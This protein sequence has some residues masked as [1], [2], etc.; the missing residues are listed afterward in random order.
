M[1]ILETE[2]EFLNP[3]IRNN[4]IIKLYK[5]GKNPDFVYWPDI[6]HILQYIKYLQSDVNNI[7][8]SINGSNVFINTFTPASGTNTYTNDT[9]LPINSYVQGQAIRVLFKNSNTG[10]STMNINSLGP[11]SLK[12]N[13]IDDL[14]NGDIIAGGIYEIQYDGTNFQITI[15]TS[16]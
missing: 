8:N 14:Q 5:P 6:I 1:V 7:N 16:L 13:V 3:Y 9:P 15:N 4:S 2:S 10:A 12:K 11:K